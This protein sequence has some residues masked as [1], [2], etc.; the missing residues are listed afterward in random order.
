MMII[1]NA[2]VYVYRIIFMFSSLHMLNWSAIAKRAMK[3]EELEIAEKH[4][5]EAIRKHKLENF[6]GESVWEPY[7]YLGEVLERKAEKVT[8]VQICCRNKGSCFK[9]QHYTT[10]QRTVTWQL[11]V[12]K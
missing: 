5:S 6:Q 1:R 4:C 8:S 3:N 9:P 7:F 10:S 11:I 12:K 2:F